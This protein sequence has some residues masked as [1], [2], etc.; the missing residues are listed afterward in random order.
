M[1]EWILRAEKDEIRKR[2]LLHT[3]SPMAEYMRLHY[4]A[5]W[6]AALEE[7]KQTPEE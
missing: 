1:R 3:P 5:A 6:L 4:P 2:A 7:D